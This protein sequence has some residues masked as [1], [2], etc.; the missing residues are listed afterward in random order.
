MINSQNLQAYYTKALICPAMT[1]TYSMLMKQSAHDLTDWYTAHANDLSF[2]QAKDISRF[3]YNISKIKL[4]N[5]TM[6]STGSK[7][8]CLISLRSTSSRYFRFKTQSVISFN[9]SALLLDNFSQWKLFNLHMIYLFICWMLVL[10][11]CLS[12]QQDFRV[13][14]W[15]SRSCL[16]KAFKLRHLI[17]LR[18]GM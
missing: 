12:L 18:L 5:M 13:S 9:R 17:H 11:P 14:N 15:F 8:C 2:V 3:Y 16:S 7:I 1:E 10:H 6:S 4:E